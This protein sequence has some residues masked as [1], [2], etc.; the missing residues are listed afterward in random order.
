MRSVCWIQQ[1]Q[2]YALG[3]CARPMSTTPQLQTAD[4]WRDPGRD[5]WFVS[6]EQ[7]GSDRTRCWYQNT[8]AV[9]CHH[10]RLQQH[11]RSTPQTRKRT[12]HLRR[13]RHP[14]LAA[15]RLGG[16]SAHTRD[17]LLLAVQ[18][19][20][21]AAASCAAHNSPHAQQQLLRARRTTVRL[22][23]RVASTDHCRRLGCAETHTAAL[24]GM[25]SS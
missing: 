2:C 22:C 11:T 1:M 20:V 17:R 24:M 10:L 7:Q 18:P 14:T 16:C 9:S 6:C 13:C 3:A 23:A 15:K 5:G 4:R 12:P 19:A 21:W 8:P 25:N